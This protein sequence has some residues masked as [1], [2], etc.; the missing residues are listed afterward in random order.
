MERSL[1]IVGN[2]FGSYGVCAELASKLT[3]AG[4][5]VTVTSRTRGKVPR[6]LDMVTTVW[7][8]RDVFAVA[9]VDV[10]S[11]AAFF[12]AETVCQALRGI[13]KPYILTLHGGNLPHFAQRWPRRV[14]RLFASAAAVTAPSRYLYDRMSDYADDLRLIPNALDVGMYQFR[15]RTGAQP[16]LLW[17]RAF[18]SIYNPA[19]CPRVL[20]LLV[21][22][23]PNLRLIMIGPDK[24]D[25]SLQFTRKVATNLRVSDRIELA[26]SVEKQM[27]PFWLDK[28]DV[29]VNTS[30]VDN[31]PISVME[32]M[33][34]GL[35]I[36]STAVGGVPC[37]LKD[38]SEA[39]LVR[40]NDPEAMADAIRKI[41]EEPR[42]AISLSEN[43]RYKVEQ[44]DWQNILP[45]WEA[46]LNEAASGFLDN[47]REVKR[48]NS[49]KTAS[50]INQ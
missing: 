21:R 48:N 20:A 9:Q 8:K 27:V 1:L 32:A 44:F 3:Q 45:Q 30:D 17:L 4:W 28:G 41:L 7:R 47:K 39:L 37:L 29:F 35:C 10:F 25:G 38:G 42:L 2:F 36:V 46:L 23:F 19:L 12:W 50:H 5:N 33:A 26:G 16:R 11:G 24:K 13:S 18:H 49:S 40:P 22:E 43:A 6:L 14:R 31:T 15:R 34:S